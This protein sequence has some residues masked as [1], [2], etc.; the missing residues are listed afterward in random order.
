MTAPNRGLGVTARGERSV[1]A[2]VSVGVAVTGDSGAEILPQE[3]LRAARDTTAPQGLANLPEVASGVFA[4][5]ASELTELRRMLTG[6]G[7][8]VIYG[9]GGTGKSTL[10][11]HY[12][13]R[14][15]GDYT[16]VW[17]VGAESPEQIRDGFAALVS[18]LRKLVLLGIA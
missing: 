15:R 7:R 11:L 13:R 8:A 3:T 9:V 4:G 10:A 17:W 12:A 14:Y 16:A 18:A 6:Q 1:A 2:S 5:R